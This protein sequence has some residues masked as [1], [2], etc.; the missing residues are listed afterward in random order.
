LRAVWVQLDARTLEIMCLPH[1][2][3]LYDPSWAL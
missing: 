2:V 1:Q 3:L